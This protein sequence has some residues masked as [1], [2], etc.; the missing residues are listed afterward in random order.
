[1][2]RHN[3]KEP[4]RPE[5][6]KDGYWLV[7]GTKKPTAGTKPPGDQCYINKQGLLGGVVKCWEPERSQLR[8]VNGGGGG[9]GGAP[10]PSLK[11]PQTPM[12]RPKNS[13]G[14]QRLGILST[15]K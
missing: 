9:A 3:P 7:S 2:S 14:R 8:K 5:V 4:R 6:S 11:P 12:N 15:D 1:M 13:Q 10:A